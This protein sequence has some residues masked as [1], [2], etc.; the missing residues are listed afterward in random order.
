MSYKHEVQT[1]KTVTFDIPKTPW[2][3]VAQQR[4]VMRKLWNRDFRLD[5]PVVRTQRSWPYDPSSAP[6]F[7]GGLCRPCP[8]GGARGHARLAGT[9][10]GRG[11]D[12]RRAGPPGGGAVHP[13]RG[14]DGAC[15]RGLARNGQPLRLKGTVYPAG[16]GMATGM[17]MRVE[18]PSP[19]RRF[20]C[21]AGVQDS[22]APTNDTPR[23]SMS[24]LM[25]AGSCGAADRC[26]PA[27]NQRLSTSRSLDSAWLS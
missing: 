17:A 4:N 9:D 1:V 14:F 16:I 11:E 24:S 19:G 18:L 5:P 27:T 20:T 26:R 8:A 15:Y 3:L 10:A 21:R 22:N 12:H 7:Y 25:T 23:C 2:E 13:Q 6:P